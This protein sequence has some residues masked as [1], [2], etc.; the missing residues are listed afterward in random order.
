MS[1]Y[2]PEEI[3]K[4]GLKCGYIKSNR[5]TNRSEKLIKV[6]IAVPGDRVTVNEDNIQVNHHSIFFDYFAP[7]ITSDKNNLP[8][9]R[10]IRKGTYV[11]KGYWVY[12]Y[13]NPQYSWDSRYYG[14]ISGEKIKNRLISLWQF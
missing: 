9:H 1:F 10:F 14:E 3:I 5:Y 12:G 6:V 11:A 4:I 8:V 7:I 13:G 2:L